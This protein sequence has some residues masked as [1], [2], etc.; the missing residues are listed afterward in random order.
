M[1]ATS[2]INI[3]RLIKGARNVFP[4]APKKIRHP[5]T[6]TILK[7][8]LPPLLTD[9]ND[10]NI[11]AAFCIAFAGF[12]RMDKF[13]NT[14]TDLTVSGANPKVLRRSDINFSENH[15][16]ATLLFRRSKTDVNNTSVRIIF[17]RTEDIACPV[18]SLLHLLVTDP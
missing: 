1:C 7:S 15:D 9:K 16:T 11:Y 14:A 10:V 4:P 17:S 2:S 13:T 6:I 18:S 5:I 12:F 8:I 3:K